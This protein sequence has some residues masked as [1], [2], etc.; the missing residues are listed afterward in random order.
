[1][2]KSKA[3]TKASK[4]SSGN[5]QSPPEDEVV[6]NEVE[7]TPADTPTKK[8]AL[9]NVFTYVGSGE[10][11]PPLINFMGLQK[12]VRGKAVEVTNPTVLQKIRNNPCFTEGEVDMEELH[13]YDQEEAEK[14]AEQR[15]K[16][17]ELN[18]AAHKKFKQSE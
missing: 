11:S 12:F 10:A 6:E 13:E 17:K 2:A 18:D 8:K 9:A 5:N 16:D 7:A 4:V 3:N 15:K 14:A 1:M